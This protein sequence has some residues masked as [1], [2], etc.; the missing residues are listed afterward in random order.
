MTDKT[1]HRIIPTTALTALLAAT[2]ILTGCGAATDDSI[3]YHDYREQSAKTATAEV[4]NEKPYED[5]VDERSG[6]AADATD[7]STIHPP[8]ANGDIAD[9]SGR[10]AADNEKLVYTANATVETTEYVDAMEALRTLMSEHDAFAEY[11]D[12]WEGYGGLMSA[13]LT[14]RVPTED[15]ASLVGGLDA[16][17]KVTSRSARV[18]NITRS[19]SDN[20]VVIAGLEAQEGRLLEMMDAASDVEDLILIEERLSDVQMRLDQANSRRDSMDADVALSTVQLDVHE[21]SRVSETGRESYGERLVYAFGDMWDSF[22]EGCGDFL[23]GAVYFI[24]FAVGLG[25]AVF[26][27]RV[28]IRR[29]RMRASASAVDEVAPSGH[30]DSRQDDYE[31]CAE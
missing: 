24:P 8:E 11:E 6:F 25:V 20:E 4:Q 30:A 26:I 19:Y 22:V 18:E 15:Y 23:I 5:A 28:V 13:S 1:S 9:G 14:I 27:V 7:A 2:I 17:G 16:I 29:R 21:V 3:Y 31:D 12:E 10:I